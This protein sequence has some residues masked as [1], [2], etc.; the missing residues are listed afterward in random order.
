[1][2][3]ALRQYEPDAVAIETVFAA[4]NVQSSI[5]LAQVRGVAL[6]AA[7]QQE[8]RIAEHSPL[9]IKQSVV[10]YGR[11]TK[12][13]VQMM[14]G[15]LLNLGSL[16]VPEDAADALAVAITH[17]VSNGVSLSQGVHVGRR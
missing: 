12:Q 1:L 11:A 9:E 6:L 7:A 13:Q 10:G 17:A 2:L 4:V 5:K 8:A 14:V 3:A 16:S 15:S